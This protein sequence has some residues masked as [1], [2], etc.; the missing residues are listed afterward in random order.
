M[1]Y[2]DSMKWRYATKKFDRNKKIESGVLNRVL[3]AG[4]LTATSLGFQPIKV[5]NVESPFLRDRIKSASFNQQQVTD[6][7]HLL[8]ICVDADFS[9]EN[10]SRYI[11]TI[12]QARE[13][14]SSDLNGFEAMINGWIAG[15][16]DDEE[17]INW[18]AKQAILL[19]V[20]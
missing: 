8:I 20:R 19:L 2:I 13:I 3:E 9:K 12:A 6:A 5:L 4:N 11:N 17:R 16:P 18:A 1:E 15:L 14:S 10:V 7:S